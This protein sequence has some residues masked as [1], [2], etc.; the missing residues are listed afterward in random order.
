MGYGKSFFQ[1]R[2]RAAN[3][4]AMKL[5]PML[6]DILSTP[7]YRPQSMLDVGCGD[8]AWLSAFAQAGMPTTVGV[9]GPWSPSA[10]A[11]KCDFDKEDGFPALPQERFDF[12]LSL[13]FFEHL[14]PEVAANVAKWVG[15]LT[16]TILFSAAS[17]DQGGTGH[18]NEQWIGY[19]AAIFADLGFEVCDFIRP[20]IWNDDEISPWY[21]Q[22]LVG[23]FRP[24][25]P[26][27]V[28]ASAIGSWEAA[29]SNPLNF[30]H[31]DI[32]KRSLGW[33]ARQ[34]LGL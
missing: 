8:G 3:A 19:W 29:I 12:V 4:S 34:R 17:P 21:R 6:L 28:Q 22:N 7:N 27:H 26:A 20:A 23:F 25:V 24:N 18:I 30:V 9:D 31:P 15:G 32:Y 1:N 10:E 11:I 5:A 13:E 16:D 14:R 2:R 33:R